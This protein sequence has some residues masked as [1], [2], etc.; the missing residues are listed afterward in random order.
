MSNEIKFLH[1]SD[2]DIQ[3][4][5]QVVGNAVNSRVYA[6][7]W[8]LNILQPDW[9]GLV[10]G[11]YIYVMPVFFSKK[12]GIHYM[13]QPIYAQ[14][15]GI[16]PPPEPEIT[17]QFISFLQ[18]KFRYF[19]VSL[20]SLNNFKKEGIEVRERKNFV[21]SLKNNYPDISEQY[22]THTKRYV[23]KASLIANISS[24]LSP[25]DF[26]KMKDKYGK[27]SIEEKYRSKLN[28]IIS[29]SIGNK[30]GV[31]YAAFSKH[32][33]TIGA[34]FFLKENAR[35]TYLSSVLSPEG[36]KQRSM[37]A[38]VDTFI[39]DHAGQ[40]VIL[41]FEGSNIEGIARFFEGFGARIETYQHLKFNN[42]PWI[43]KLFK[44]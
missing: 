8:Y 12:W 15:H 13:F 28:Q 23:K 21:L 4:W 30:E 34:A 3:K 32:N 18:K 29:S 33:E 31:I 7:S 26:L 10:Y 35:Y 38:I 17:E 6:L 27:L 1:N 25:D 16:F 40:P 19:N 42:L 44:K 39:R 24:Q 37:Y 36:K 22:T 14:Q 20:N 2:I 11:D 41:D 5:D 9:H 43:V